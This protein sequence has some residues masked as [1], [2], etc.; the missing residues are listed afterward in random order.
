VNGKELRPREQHCD[1]L[2][3]AT[4]RLDILERASDRLQAKET[5]LRSAANL[6]YSSSAH[7]NE[8]VLA[9]DLSP[10]SAVS[11]SW[12]PP[13]E[14]KGREPTIREY[15][16]FPTDDVV[17]HLYPFAHPVAAALHRA[18]ETGALREGDFFDKYLRSALSLAMGSCNCETSRQ[19]ANRARK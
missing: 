13:I 12:T 3:Y 1:D 19:L 8:L 17:R 10:S 7:E 9:P 4:K 2:A 16:D 14:N 11:Q 5:E 6:P 15:G 18:Y